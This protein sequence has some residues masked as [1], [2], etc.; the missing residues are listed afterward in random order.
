MKGGAGLGKEG[1]GE[2][3]R[4]TGEEGLRGG[5]G[6]GEWRRRNTVCVSTRTDGGVRSQWSSKAEPAFVHHGSM[7]RGLGKWPLQTT[8]HTPLPILPFL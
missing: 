3:R 7:G 4:N 2:K 6:E 5:W 8:K 1:G